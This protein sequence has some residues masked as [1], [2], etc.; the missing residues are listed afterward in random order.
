MGD[1]FSYHC[2]SL[3]YLF[4]YLDQQLLGD[5]E[6]KVFVNLVSTN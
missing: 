5:T 6:L 1:T 2:A 4:L 3:K